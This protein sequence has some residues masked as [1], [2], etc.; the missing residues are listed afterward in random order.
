M[1]TT[2]AQI[3]QYQLGHV[4]N[5]AHSWWEDIDVS[6]RKIMMGL[7][8]RETV[9]SALVCEDLARYDPVL[10][11]VA[12]IGPSLVIA[13]LMDGP[14][15]ENR[16]SARYATTLA[17]DPGSSVLTLTSLGMILRSR[18]PGQEIRRTIGI[19]RERGESAIEL[20]LP[21]GHHAISLSLIAEESARQRTLDNRSDGG[22]AMFYR[23]GGV[24]SLALN[25]P[26]DFIER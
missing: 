1:L 4:L 10:P 21:A 15:L 13:L 7:D 3:K 22:A 12:A 16:W 2:G 23:L 18:R 11:A 25:L 9:I 24:H 20:E 5:P 6:E 17:E 19:W 26:P 14:Q 8:R